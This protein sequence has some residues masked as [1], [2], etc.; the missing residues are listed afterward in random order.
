M[1]SWSF[2]AVA[3]ASG[4]ADEE[5]AAKRELLARLR[6]DAALSSW[7]RSCSYRV[8]GR[9]QLE[10]LVRATHAEEAETKRREEKKAL[11]EA[12]DGDAAGDADAA[13]EREDVKAV[14]VTPAL[15]ALAFQRL[16]GRD[17]R[18]F[19][20]YHQTDPSAAE[21]GGGA[22]E[23][24]QPLVADREI[25]SSEESEEDPAHP[26]TRVYLLVDYPTSLAEITALLRLGETLL[27]HAVETEAARQVRHGAEWGP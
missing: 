5:L 4:T 13:E 23:P 1:G 24:L 16:V 10:E 6:A 9:P 7:Q 22:G 8:V 17:K 25:H 26:P 11:Q 3:V 21:G 15:L 18:E 19:L 12:A 2:H 27:Q 20:A 14:A